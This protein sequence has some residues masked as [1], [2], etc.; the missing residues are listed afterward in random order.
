MSESAI[1]RALEEHA[2]SAMEES[3]RTQATLD[4]RQ[5]TSQ[6]TIDLDE[7]TGGH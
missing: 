1:E 6:I 3:R 7:H 2:G 4:I 5:S